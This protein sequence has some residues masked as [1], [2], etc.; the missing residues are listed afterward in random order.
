MKRRLTY[1]QAA[2]ELPE[3]V[4]ESWLRRHIKRLPHTKI[5]RVVY[6]TDAD[7][8]RIDALFHHEPSTG[9][10]A[11]TATAPSA[12]AHPLSHLRPLPGRGSA[13]ART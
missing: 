8:E 7:L 12:G 5:G 13:L 6:F 2:D 1:A 9:P 4:T 3:G 11:V 10:L